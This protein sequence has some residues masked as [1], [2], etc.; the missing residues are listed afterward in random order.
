MEN[1]GAPSPSSSKIESVAHIML[2]VEVHVEDILSTID[3]TEPKRI[4]QYFI[5]I[6]KL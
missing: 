6:S 3:L 4:I 5:W 2:E 1:W